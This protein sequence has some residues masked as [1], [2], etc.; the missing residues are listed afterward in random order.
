MLRPGAAVL[1]PAAAAAMTRAA[2]DRLTVALVKKILHAP[3]T[4]LR[5]MAGSPQEAEYAAAA[6]A[7]FDLEVCN[8]PSSHALAQTTASPTMPTRRL[9]NPL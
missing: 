6:R 7:L 3:I 4:R 2:V 9:E 8:L 5:T 1:R